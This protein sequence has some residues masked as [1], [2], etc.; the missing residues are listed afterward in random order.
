[1]TDQSSLAPYFCRRIS[2]AR[3]SESTPP[4]AKESFMLRSS[5]FESFHRLVCSLC[6]RWGQFV[7]VFRRR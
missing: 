2:R 5:Q 1:V 3:P 7:E 6:G 4:A